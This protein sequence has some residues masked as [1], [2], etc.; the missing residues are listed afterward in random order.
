GHRADPV[1][2]DV[3]GR[4]H[5]DHVGHR[6]A[7]LVLAWRRRRPDR[8]GDRARHPGH[9]GPV[10]RVERPAVDGPAV[11]GCRARGWGGGRCGGPGGAGAQLG[12]VRPGRHHHRGGAGVPGARD[13]GDRSDLHPV[14]AAG[15]GGQRPAGAPRPT[16][17]ALTPAGQASTSSRVSG[18]F[19]AGRWF[20]SRSTEPTSSL[21]AATAADTVRGGRPGRVS[22]WWVSTPR[23]CLAWW[24]TTVRTPAFSATT[25][26]VS[27]G[28]L[29]GGFQAAR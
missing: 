6:T 16:V 3:G 20:T 4:D 22:R 18:P 10:R 1:L 25:R 29:A 9:P 23:V 17:R 27:H 2:A 28:V 15:A 7:A 21:A 13:P 24:E 8:C 14:L 26:T 5:G 12:A 19:A 11:A